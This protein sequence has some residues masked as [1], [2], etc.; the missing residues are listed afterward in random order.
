[1][2]ITTLLLFPWFTGI[3]KNN[4][5]LEEYKKMLSDG[6]SATS[7]VQVAAVDNGSGIGDIVAVSFSYLVSSDKPFEAPVIIFKFLIYPVTK[8][9]WVQSVT[10]AVLNLLFIIAKILGKNIKGQSKIKNLLQLICNFMGYGHV[11]KEYF[12]GVKERCSYGCVA[13]FYTPQ[14]R[15]ELSARFTKVWLLKNIYNNGMFFGL[16][17]IIGDMN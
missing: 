17:V 4:A 10:L 3:A 1:M 11:L 7:F 8:N 16:Y 9:P 6:P 13:F 15:F 2:F 14:K 12:A 5:A